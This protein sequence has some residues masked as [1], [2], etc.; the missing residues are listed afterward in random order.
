MRRPLQPDKPRAAEASQ[1]AISSPP[2]F[3]LKVMF[4][5]ALSSPR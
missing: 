5:L 2:F 3:S 4:D 1:A